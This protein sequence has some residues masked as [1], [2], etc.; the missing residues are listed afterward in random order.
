M[1]LL[2]SKETIIIDAFCVYQVIFKIII[3]KTKHQ[4]HFPKIDIVL[5]IYVNIRVHR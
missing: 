4:I 5:F 2:D 1:C 3:F